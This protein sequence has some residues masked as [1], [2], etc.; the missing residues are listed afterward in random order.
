MEKYGIIVGVKYY[1]CIVDFLG[2][3]GRL[4]EVFD[5]VK[6]ML[7]KLNNIIWGFLFGVC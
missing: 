5:V 3:G 1:G 7:M 2:R 6:S 4:K